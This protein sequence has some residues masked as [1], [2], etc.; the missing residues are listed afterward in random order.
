MRIKRGETKRQKHNKVLELAKGYRM[1]YSKSYRR[2]KE[3]VRHAGQYSYAHRRRRSS[4]M[5]KEW[6]KVISASLS[7][8]NLDLSYSKFI[9][10]L[11]TNNIEID[12]KILAEL[13]LYK[14]DHFKQLVSELK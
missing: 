13:A 3:A 12:R 7:S 2:A 1:T 9:N 11:N 5:R 10:K 14:E 6:I 4:Q 8:M